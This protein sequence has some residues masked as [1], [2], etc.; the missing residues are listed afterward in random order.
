MTLQE[1]FDV[2]SNN[3]S[4]T[5]FYFIALPLTAVL[6]GVLGKQRGHESPWKYVYCLLL[7]MAAIPGIFAIF[8]NVY[9]FLF[10]RQSVMQM[11]LF[12]Q[13]IPVITMFLSFFII[14]KN[15]DLS[16]IPGF[17]RLSGL[18][19]MV[20]VLIGLM[21]ILDSTKILAIT[22][23][24]FQYVLLILVGALILLRFGWSKLAIKR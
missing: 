10:E 22:F 17:D 1:L 8:L 9:L 3:P 12:T 4:I 20:A 15:V 18:V 6:C 14:R 13:V 11:N 2:L 23:I 16:L 24:P 7:Y 21:W 5:L 19:L